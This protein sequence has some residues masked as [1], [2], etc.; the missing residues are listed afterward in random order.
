M[1]ENKASSRTVEKGK[2]ESIEIDGNDDIRA[3]TFVA[4]GD[5]IVNGDG[6]KIRRRRVKDGKE[7]GRPIDAGSVVVSIAVSQDGKWIVSGTYDGKVTLWDAGSQKKA[8]EFRGHNN[9]VYAMDISPDRT[10][11][12]TGSVDKTVRVWSFSTGEQLLGP[13]K[14]DS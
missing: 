3:I 12:A 14:H 6:N 9:A 1:N 10:R 4:D 5:Y 13:F 7:D 11:I 8:I 2:A